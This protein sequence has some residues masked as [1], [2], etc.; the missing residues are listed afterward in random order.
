MVYLGIKCFYTVL[1]E[2]VLENSAHV[3][4][5]RLSAEHPTPEIVL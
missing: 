3:S 2:E 5:Q 4:T 1:S